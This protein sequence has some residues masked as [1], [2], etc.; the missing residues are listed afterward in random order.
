MKFLYHATLIIL[1]FNGLMYLIFDIPVTR[2]TQAYSL[3][4]C[5]YFLAIG[6]KFSEEIR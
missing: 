1:A 4:S 5:V 6:L 3:F 2:F